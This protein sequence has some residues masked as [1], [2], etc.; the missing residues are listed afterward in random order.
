[1]I[2]YFGSKEAL[3]VRAVDFDLRLPDLGDVAPG[4]IGP[5]LVRHFLGVW[6]GEGGNGGLTILL[7]SAAVEPD[8][9]GRSCARCSRAR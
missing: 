2:R 4:A 5:A 6:E 9:R 7:R 3:F 8:R 1:M